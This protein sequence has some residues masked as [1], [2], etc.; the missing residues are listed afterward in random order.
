MS[1][2][3]EE[4]EEPAVTLGEASPV[5]GAPISRVAS[6]I[7]WPRAKS[8]VLEAEGDEPIRT[9]EGAVPLTAILDDVEIS[10]FARR[11]EFVDAV[12]EVIGYDPVPAVEEATEE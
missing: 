3:E 11:Q 7:S 6:R 8:A 9:S 2:E 12:R 10:Y 4:A 1:G 5:E